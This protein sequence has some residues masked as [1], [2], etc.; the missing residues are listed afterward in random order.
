MNF[1][2][3]WLPRFLS[4]LCLCQLVATGLDGSWVQDA[5][6]RWLGRFAFSL[7]G[8]AT[9]SVMMSWLAFRFYK[10]PLPLGRTGIFLV[11]LCTLIAGIIAA[12]PARSVVSRWLSRGLM[13]VFACLALYSVLC[14]RL[15]YFKEYEWDADVKDVYSVMARL[16]H[17][18][19]VTDAGVTGL[20]VTVLNYYRV[21]SARETFPKFELETPELSVGRSIY[22]MDGVLWREFIDK[23]KLV[24]VYRG[25]FS[26]VVVAVKPHGPIPPTMIEP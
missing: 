13:A 10:L 20:Y 18:Y 6:A 12:V 1:L 22:V 23:E 4:I 15:S 25:K 3:P 19:G 26:D 17:A 21:L 8:I 7:V 14:L 16:N 11:P 2:G 24:V 5:R 9:L